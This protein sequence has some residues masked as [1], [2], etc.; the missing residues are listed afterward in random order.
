MRIF[1]SS[2]SLDLSE[3]RQRILKLLSVVPADLVHMEMFGSDETLPLDYALEQVRRSDLFIGVYA[4]RYGSIDPSTG[5]SITELEYLEAR[6]MLAEGHLS[7]LLVYLLDPKAD[8]RVDQIDRDPDRISALLALKDELKSKHTI[9]FFK[10]TEDLSLNVLRDVLRKIGIG[11]GT[12]L[13]IR[14]VFAKPE[15]RPAQPLGMEHYTERDARWFRGREDDIASI[16]EL[17][18]KNSEALLIGDSG[19]GKTSLV[20][21]GVFPA[22]RKM[23][24]LVASCRPLDS[25]DESIPVAVWHQLMEGPPP[26]QTIHTILS[27]VSEAHGNKKLLVVVDQ[28]EDIIPHL[29]TPRASNL[30]SALTQIYTSPPANLHLLLCYRGDAEPRVG[31]YWQIVSGSA[32]GLPRYYLGPLGRE[33]ARNVLMDIAGPAIDFVDEIVYDTEAESIRSL[34]V[35]IYPPFL[36]MVAETCAKA[37]EESGTALSRSEYHSLGKARQIIGRYLLNELR[38]LGPRSKESQAVMI[39]LAGH[40][41]RFRKTSE[42]ISRDTSVPLPGVEAC[43]ADLLNLR[44]VHA[45]SG[46]RWEIVHDFLA[47]RVIED[48]IAPEDYEARLFRDVVAAKAGVYARNAEL[49]TYKEHLGAYAHR[50]RIVLTEEEVELLFASSL[51]GNGPV[52]YFLRTL[53]VELPLT[54]AGQYVSSPKEI[55]REDSTR[56]NACRFLV[57]SGKHVSLSLLANI[58]SDYKLQA[59]LATF[60][61]SYSTRDDLNLLLKLRIKKAEQT[62][63]AAVEQLEGMVEPSDTVLIERFQKSRRPADTRLLCRIL[64]TKIRP[65][66]KSDLWSDLGKRKIGPRILAICGL[67]A[68][69]DEAD[70][71]Q[72]IERLRSPTLSTRERETSGYALAH[73]AQTKG[74]W[75]LLTKLFELDD[76]VCRGALGATYNRGNLNVELLLQ[77]YA[78]LPS[79]TAAAILR[80][81]T[82]EDRPALE[83]FLSAS[84]LNPEM[85]DIIIALLNIGGSNS[86]RW[87]LELIG[88]KGY[89]VVFWNTPILA[90]A[91]TKA[92]G[93]E[94]KSWLC[95]LADSDE[96]WHYT[97]NERTSPPLPVENVENLYLF[98]R[99]TDVALASLC[100]QSDWL[101]LK[102]LI[103]H[104][105]WT[106]QVAA[107]FQVAK[108]AGVE[109]LNELVQQARSEARDQPDA[110]VVNALMLLDTK[111]FGQEI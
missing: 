28:L 110:G 93:I 37:A 92:V 25:P 75:D 27:L 49:L 79:E 35:E 26:D 15:S 90:A 54:W 7:G 57:A 38:L 62:R 106:I 85:R 3:A 99:L 52:R 55:S 66:S 70:A 2:T 88:Q 12:A 108:F 41:R 103:F 58:F 73:W 22:L 80:T 95:N 67:G 43:L 60:I 102:R 10:N 78:R 68:H 97:G 59:E 13:R 1:L 11:H 104:K 101:L 34:G 20:Q 45:I 65:A 47:Q 98:K 56:I 96:F 89:K 105:Y 40:L 23:D 18:E 82:V 64:I 83:Q 5:K 8:W 109:H 94:M 107:A 87:I 21:A 91:I 53:P 42:E 32:S 71:Y 72:L 111:L 50:Q 77:Q 29:D 46:G 9:T 6:K 24:W 39:S 51:A 74:R 31:H 36:Q 14:K 86:A 76:G 63:N 44:L 33:A 100:D 30:L 48:L 4:E 69:G 16:C 19:I 17:V 84:L 81:A 61:R